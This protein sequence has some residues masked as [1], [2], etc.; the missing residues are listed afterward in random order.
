MKLKDYLESNHISIKFFSEKI[1]VTP[2]YIYMIIKGR[3]PSLKVCK[4]I[5]SV[6]QNKVN[7]YDFYEHPLNLEISSNSISNLSEPI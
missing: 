3:T 1:N 7:R 5:E 4:K 2:Q 6:T